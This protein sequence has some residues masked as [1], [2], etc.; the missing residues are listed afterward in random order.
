V[1]QVFLNSGLTV[2]FNQVITASP[3]TY[4]QLYVGLFT[5]LSGT[6]VPATT[7]TIGSGITEVS[8]QNYAR[9]TVTYGTPAVATSYTTPFGTTT[10]N[11]AV[12]SGVQVVTLASVAPSGKTLT[13]GMSIVVGTESVKVVTAIVGNQVVLSSPLAS[14]QSNGATVT[15]G[16]AVTGMKSVPASNSVFSAQGTWTAANGFFIATA[17]TGGTAL[18]AANFADASSPV[19][20][21]NDSLNFTPTWL[22][23]N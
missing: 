6:T 3:V 4:S 14:N 21:A 5:G 16:D 12:S 11:G 19:L 2:L 13:L 23:S 17:L 10:L 9:Q 15:F 20:T 22:M 1:A 7:A 18:Y 8:G